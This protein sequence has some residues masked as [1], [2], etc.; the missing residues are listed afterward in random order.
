MQNGPSNQTNEGPAAGFI[1]VAVLWIVAALA[2]LVVVFALYLRAVIP[3]FV[4]HKDRLHARA[5]EIAGVELAVQRFATATDAR[6]SID[7]FSFMLDGAVIEVDCR[8]ESGRIDLN[9]APKEMLAGLF[10]EFGARADDA[11]N[12]T[13]RIVAWRSSPSEGATTDEGILYT[14]AGL[15]YGPRRKPFQHVNELSLVLG[16]PPGLIDRILPYVTV[17]SGQ[18][19]IN[20]FAAAPEVLAA[21]PRLTPER[22]QSLLALRDGGPQDSLNVRLGAAAQ[23][24]TTQGSRAN[25]ITVNVKLAAGRQYQAEAV[26]L[27]MDQDTE[28][29]RL[30]SWRDGA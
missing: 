18:A 3:E 26:V 10:V 9:H 25:R 28:P 23:F 22:L 13:D 15:S 21:M 8:A 7:R 4:D 17:F 14:S 30:L 2:A 29:Y 16:A 6:P 19:E 5:L 20:V 27:I 24:A 11:R 12:F 1:L